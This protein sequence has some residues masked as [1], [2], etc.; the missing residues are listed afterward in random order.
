MFAGLVSTQIFKQRDRQTETVV[1][2]TGWRDEEIQAGKE[3]KE[4]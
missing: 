4:L 1:A 3:G 2:G